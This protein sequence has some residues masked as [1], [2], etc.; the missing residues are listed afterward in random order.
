LF[1]EDGH[2]PTPGIE[3][4]CF[5]HVPRDGHPDPAFSGVRFGS[6]YTGPASG[7]KG[8][9]P[10]ILWPH[11][12]PHSLTSNSFY[13]EVNFF[14]ELGYG[15]LFVNFRGS[16]GAGQVPKTTYSP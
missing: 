3:T 9:V 7:E 8:S 4:R 2:N 5:R 11:G 6:V 13:R 10:L 12:G 15:V 16:V 14:N 1:G